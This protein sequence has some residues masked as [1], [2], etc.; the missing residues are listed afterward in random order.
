MSGKII[1]P[2]CSGEVRDWVEDGGTR[3]IL[4]CDKCRASRIYQGDEVPTIMSEILWIHRTDAI[5]EWDHLYQF[6]TDPLRYDRK[7]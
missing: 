6:N 3:L 2:T 1:C 7:V 5:I 4:V